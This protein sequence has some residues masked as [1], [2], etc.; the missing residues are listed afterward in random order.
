MIL[1]WWGHLITAP[2]NQN[3]TMYPTIIK[4]Y[5]IVEVV[6]EPNIVATCDE[7]VL[8]ARYIIGLDVTS[9]VNVSRSNPIWI[10]WRLNV[11]WM[12]LPEHAGTQ[13]TGALAFY[14][15]WLGYTCPRDILTHRD[16]AQRRTDNE[17][18]MSRLL[19]QVEE[20]RMNMQQLQPQVSELLQAMRTPAPAPEPVSNELSH[21]LG[22]LF[23]IRV[24]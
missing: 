4:G 8:H 1:W 21:E 7:N 9:Q 14:H 16:M 22:I 5:P 19:Q 6:K 11:S 17:D 24:A 13:T 12:W 15:L 2:S 20:L 18:K 10:H 23:S 3:N